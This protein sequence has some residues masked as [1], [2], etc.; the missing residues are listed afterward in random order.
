MAQ[1]KFNESA[2][3]SDDVMARY[4]AAMARFLL[5]HDV[6][7]EALRKGRTLTPFEEE[8]EEHARAAL[9]EARQELS[10]P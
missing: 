1:T 9:Y 5:A 6:I 10:R 4:S 7:S 8:E 3:P 2:S